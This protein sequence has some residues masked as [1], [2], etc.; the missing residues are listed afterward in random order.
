MCLTTTAAGAVSNLPSFQIQ[1]FFQNRLRLDRVR[2]RILET[3]FFGAPLQ[4]KRTSHHGLRREHPRRAHRQGAGVAGR[5]QRAASGASRRAP[6]A[7]ARG[8]V[9]AVQGQ[10][11]AQEDL[12]GPARGQAGVRH[13]QDGA[14]RRHRRS[15]AGCR[16]AHRAALRGRGVGGQPQ[17]VHQAHGED[18]QPVRC[19]W[20]RHQAR[21]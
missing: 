2:P 16:Q 10:S 21:H 8:R 12:Q 1:S 19:R 15:A 17:D 3:G 4:T 20:L 14:A 11:Q 13:P 6:S 9:H 18:G 7:R 5:G